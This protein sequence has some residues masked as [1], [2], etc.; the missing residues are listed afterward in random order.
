M[1]AAKVAVEK[2]EAPV[3]WMITWMRPSGSPITTNDTKETI[4][5]A[6]S[7]GW[8]REGDSELRR[9]ELPNTPEQA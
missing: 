4:A 5:F 7:L 6:E 8:T 9:G 2:V 3:K 1:S